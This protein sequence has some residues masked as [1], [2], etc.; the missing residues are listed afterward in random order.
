MQVESSN[1][2]LGSLPGASARLTGPAK[3]GIRGLLSGEAGTAWQETEF[4]RIRRRRA[5]D[6]RKAPVSVL[7]VLRSWRYAKAQPTTGARRAQSRSAVRPMLTICACMAATLLLV[8]P[9]LT[10]E[11]DARG[12]G[13]HGGGHG[14]GFGGHRGGISVGARGGGRVHAAHVGRAHVGRAHV[15]TA[16]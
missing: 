4:L 2:R 11:A 15:G 10:L 13:G 6:R 9:L 7:E 8:V 14:G 1:D 5:G 12:G 3:S 16:H